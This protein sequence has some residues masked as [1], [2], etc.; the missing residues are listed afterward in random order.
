[1]PY[2]DHMSAYDTTL[3]G[4][5]GRTHNFRNPNTGVM[6]NSSYLVYAFKVDFDGTNGDLT[7]STLHMREIGNSVFGTE[8][9]ITGLFFKPTNAA[10]DRILITFFRMEAPSTTHGLYSMIVYFRDNITHA[11]AV[12]I[13][14][15]TFFQSVMLN[16]GG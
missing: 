6:D 10:K 8:S 7:A 14:D 1:M 2:I 12:K 13:S 16:N 4:T 3:I 11:T 15:G 9:Y 5:A